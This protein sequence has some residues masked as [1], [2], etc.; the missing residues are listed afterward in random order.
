MATKTIDQL[1]GALAALLTQEFEIYDPAGSPKSQKITGLQ[2]LTLFFGGASD[3]LQL[4]AVGDTPLLIDQN[5]AGPGN[6]WTM[7]YMASGGN[8]IRLTMSQSA[9]GFGFTGG[10]GS[11]LQMFTYGL[12]LIDAGGGGI[13]TDGAGNVTIDSLTCGN[14]ASGTFMSQDGFTVTV[15]GGIITSIV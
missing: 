10:G 3:Q 4:N 1:T 15:A 6:G 14:G 5:D 2:L 13:H 12:S 9:C 7:R 11:Q 8:G